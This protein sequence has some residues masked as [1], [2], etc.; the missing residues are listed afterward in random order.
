MNTA[1][2]ISSNTS[3]GQRPPQAT[4][5]ALDVAATAP[6]AIRVIRRNGKV[7]GFDASKINIAVTKAFP[8][9][10][11]GCV[12]PSSRSPSRW[13]RPSPAT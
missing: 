1:N 2:V 11:R 10:A 5:S 12:K 8:P 4:G 9:P 3:S 13:C 7:T 6:G